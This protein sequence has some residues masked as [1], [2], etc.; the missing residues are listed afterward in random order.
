[1]SYKIQSSKDEL[2]EVLREAITDLTKQEHDLHLVSKEGHRIR[3]HKALLFFY[4]HLLKDIFNETSASEPFYISIPSSSSASISSL[5]KVLVTGKSAPSPNLELEEV[6][7]TAK[8]LG[9]NLENC[10]I[11]IDKPSFSTSAL[12]VASKV[13]KKSNIKSLLN[14]SLATSNLT[15]VL[16]EETGQD[17]VEKKCE[18]CN[19]VFSTNSNLYKHRR[20]QHG[21]L[22]RIVLNKDNIDKQYCDKCGSVFKARKHLIRHRRN[23]HGLETKRKT[24]E[25]SNIPELEK[26]FKCEF[27]IKAFN[28][29]SQM[30]VH[31]KKF[32]SDEK[33]TVHEDPLE[34]DNTLEEAVIDEDV[35]NVEVAMT[36]DGICKYCGEMFINN[37]DLSNHIYYVHNN[38]S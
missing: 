25:F 31:Q 33:M 9:I 15:M 24:R 4:S 20:M 36:V 23:Q 18:V 22:K 6:K 37:D 30:K 28:Q 2:D 19:N 1:M 17:Q 32:H 3:T 7:K 35:D 27:C 26:Q 12:T 14:D 34:F 21:L 38:N 5:L 29:K 10:S 8:I 13:T 16:K 11:N